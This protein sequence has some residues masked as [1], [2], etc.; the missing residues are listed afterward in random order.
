MLCLCWMAANCSSVRDSDT[1]H[2]ETGGDPD[3]EDEDELLNNELVDA[4]GH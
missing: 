1:E 3:E 2:V 4:Y